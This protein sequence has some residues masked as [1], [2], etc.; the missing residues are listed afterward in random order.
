MR[1]VSGPHEDRREDSGLTQD[2]S[3]VLQLLG[4]DQ[5]RGLGHHQ[6][7]LQVS[8][9]LLQTERLTGRRGTPQTV[10]QLVLT[11]DRF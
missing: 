11:E 3:V 2:V 7:V 5:D 1:T 8:A 10:P 9:L 6:P 4:L